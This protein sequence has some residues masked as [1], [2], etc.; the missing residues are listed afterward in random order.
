MLSFLALVGVTAA[1]P[2]AAA[3]PSYEYSSRYLTMRDGVRIAV[4]L[5]LPRTMAPGVKLPTVLLQTRYFRA[6]RVAWPASAFWPGLLEPR[7]ARFV[8]NGYAFVAVDARGSGAS[9]GTR[10]QEWSPDEVRDGA[11]IMDW[12]VAQPWSNGRSARLGSH[13]TEPRRSLR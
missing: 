8:K 12:I 11:E 13:A 4:D 1:T 9:F 5:Y 6:H 7:I 2:L 3:S 10:T